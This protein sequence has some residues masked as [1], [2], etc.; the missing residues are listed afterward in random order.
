VSAP[1]IRLAAVGD[2]HVEPSNA[3]A[4]RAAL[5]PCSAE[6]DLLLLAGDLTQ[7]GSETEARALV[8][9]LADI[10]IDIAAVLGN[11]DYELDGAV[12]LA[13]IF[14]D[15]GIHVLEGESWVLRV[16]GTRVGVAGVKGFCGGF[17]GASASEFGEPE[18]KSFM[19]A[20]RRS[21]ERLKQALLELHCDFRVVLMHYAPIP[22]TLEGEVPGLHPFLGSQLLGEAID[23]AGADLVL[24]GHAHRGRERGRTA[25]GIPVRN[26]AVPVIRRSYRVYALPGA[27]DCASDAPL[28][29][30][31]EIT[32]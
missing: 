21:A 26:V 25:R 13:Q 17:E 28:G 9:A 8:S 4:W 11:H 32:A 3:D 5:E 14:A 30:E 12:R 23:E 19:A 27:V 2:L 22:G 7:V 24:H 1:L 10:P 29:P 15:A 20:T 31:Q 6:A 16:H 18:M